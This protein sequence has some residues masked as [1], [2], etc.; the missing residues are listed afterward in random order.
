MTLASPRAVLVA[1]GITAERDDYFGRPIAILKQLLGGRHECLMGP[2]SP[3][4]WSVSKGGT[5]NTTRDVVSETGIVQR[6]VGE[7]RIEIFFFC[8]LPTAP[9]A[10]LVS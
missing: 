3:I 2:D 7:Y 9:L 4:S 5:T 8:Q 1:R 6:C 10:Q